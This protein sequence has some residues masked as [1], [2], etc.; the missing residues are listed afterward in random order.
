MDKF[1]SINIELHPSL[2]KK[3]RNGAS[4]VQIKYYPGITAASILRDL[5][6]SVDI[7]AVNIAINNIITDPVQPLQ[8]G[9][10]MK[11]ILAIAGG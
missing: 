1:Q 10:N 6:P 11:V 9:D 4:K 3:T 7:K 5:I 8:P 2:A